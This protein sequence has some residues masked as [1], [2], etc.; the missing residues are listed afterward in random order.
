M[1]NPSPQKP[2]GRII[3]LTAQAPIIYVAGLAIGSLVHFF[4]PIPLFES[5][6]AQ[7][8]G[9]ILLLLSPVLILWSQASIRQFRKDVAS[10]SVTEKNFAQG[11]YRYSR[12]PTYLG[13]FLLLIGFGFIANGLLIVLGVALSFILI[14]FF[15]LRRE[16]GILEEKYGD[17]YRRYKSSVRRWL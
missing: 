11:L 1:V 6:A 5:Q 3:T 10:G 16:E 9:L 8:V 15:I 12:N 4:Y 2:R 14:H 7:S 17:E 13:T